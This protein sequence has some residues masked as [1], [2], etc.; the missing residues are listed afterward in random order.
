MLRLCLAGGLGR[1]GRVIA[2]LVADRDDMAIASILETPAAVDSVEDYDTEVGYSRNPVVLTSDANEA[3]AA[4]EVVVD[5]S[6]PDA[7]GAVVRACEEASAPLVTGTTGI[8][9]KQGR[10]K[11]LAGKVAVVDAPNMSVGMNIVFALCRTLGDIIGRTSD[12]EVVE[13][14]HRTKKDVPSGTALKI[15]GILKECTGKPVV[16]GRSAGSVGRGEEIAVHSLRAGDVAGVHSVLF[17]PE[18]ETLELTH[19]ARSRVCFAEGALRAVR[20]VSEASP[21]LYDML[22]VLGLGQAKEGQ[23]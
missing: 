10:L 1:M 9:D 14:H 3:V 20:F 16:V 7:F 19:T 2:G 18:G 8:S 15:A 22:H 5:F 11:T 4:A 21:G 17:A 6:L 23:P 12:L 13:T